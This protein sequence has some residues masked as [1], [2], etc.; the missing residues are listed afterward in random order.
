LIFVIFI[1]NTAS[2]IS[3]I[4]DVCKLKISQIAYS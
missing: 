2:M 3:N 4:D 1:E